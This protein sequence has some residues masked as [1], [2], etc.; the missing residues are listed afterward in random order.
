MGAGR[1]AEGWGRHGGEGG[2]RGRWWAGG[3]GQKGSRRMEKQ[4]D[5][6]RGSGQ[7]DGRGAG[8]HGKVNAGEQEVLV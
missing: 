5:G 2:R 6:R 1:V 8:P 3:N 7:V 4:V